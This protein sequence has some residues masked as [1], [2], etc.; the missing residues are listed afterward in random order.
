MKKHILLLAVLAVGITVGSFGPTVLRQIEWQG[1]RYAPMAL[2]CVS[3]A[4][5]V[6][7]SML[8]TWHW[9]QKLARKHW[10]PP[11][12]PEQALELIRSVVYKPGWNIVNLALSGTVISGEIVF[13]VQDSDK[14]IAPL[15]QRVISNARTFDID[16]RRVGN[17]VQ[18]LRALL[19]E[20]GWLEDHERDEFFKVR[21]PDGTYYA[22][23][24]PHRADGIRRAEGK[25]I[26]L[27]SRL[28][29]GRMHRPIRTEEELQ[30]L[31]ALW[32]EAIGTEAMPFEVIPRPGYSVYRFINGHQA[33]GLREACEYMTALLRRLP[34]SGQGSRTPEEQAEA[35]SARPQRKE[36]YEDESREHNSSP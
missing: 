9:A 28:K 23:F 17:E 16:T 29:G 33:L 13:I 10:G 4:A 24:H 6:L 14:E 15:Y 30:A 5:W 22:P 26:P 31:V 36:E 2:Y 11:Y 1:L 27:T 25:D 20:F 7:G 32:Q 19:L 8:A 18:L 12:D 3:S 34:T 35:G 21:L